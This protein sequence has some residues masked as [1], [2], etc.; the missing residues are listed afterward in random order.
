MESDGVR[1]GREE[2]EDGEKGI[3]AFRLR[4]LAPAIGSLS[5]RASQ[6]A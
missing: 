5:A 6:P 2:K 1:M 3:V 4:L